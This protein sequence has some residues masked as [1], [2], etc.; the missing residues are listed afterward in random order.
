MANQQVNKSTRACRLVSDPSI[1][2][3]AALH[4]VQTEPA[5]PLTG[6][7]WTNK[8]QQQ[9]QQQANPTSPRPGCGSC[10]VAGLVAS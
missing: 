9:Q 3:T 8:Q 6:A 1:T 5:D 2:L 7:T 10:A 4:V